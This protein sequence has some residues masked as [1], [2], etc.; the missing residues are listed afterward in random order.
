M[1]RTT[2][3]TKRPMISAYL[4]TCE[5]MYSAGRWRRLTW[6][7]PALSGGGCITQDK[8]DKN[9]S[10]SDQ[11]G[12][13]PVHTFIFFGRRLILVY[14]ENTQDQTCEGETRQQVQRASPGWATNAVEL[15]K[16]GLHGRLSFAPHL[17]SWVRTLLRTV[18]KADPIGA[19][20]EKVAKAT[21]RDGPGGNALD[22]IP[23]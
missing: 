9:K 4:T 1:T 23:S 10:G 5:N 20:A 2:P 13:D 7:L 3:K 21:E 22:K 11:S 8:N 14:G 18:L 15:R 12:P 19:P 6:S 17:V 16:L